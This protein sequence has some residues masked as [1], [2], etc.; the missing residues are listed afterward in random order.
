MRAVVL[1]LFVIASVEMC[2]QV[3]NRLAARHERIDQVYEAEKYGETIKLIDAQLDEAMG[4]PWADSLHLYLYK[5]GRAHRKMKD[6]AAGIAAA[7]RIYTLVKERGNAEHELEALFDLSWTYYDVG[8]MRQCARVDSTAIAVADRDPEMPLSQRGRASQYLAFD[9]SVL[10]DHR[11]SA[12]YALAALEVYAKADSIPPAQW[13]ESYTAVGVAYWHLGRIREAEVYYT[14]ALEALGDGTS[15][16]ILS[17]KVS[18]YG[19]LGVMWQNAGDFTRSKTYY[20]A[21]LRNSDRV[22][23]AATDPFVRD[24]AIVNRSRTYLN[25]ATVHFQLGDDGRARELLDIAWKDRSAVLEADDPQLLVVRDRMADLELSAGALDKAEELVSAYLGS[26]ERKFGKRSEEYIRACSKLGDIALRKGDLSRADSLFNVSIAAGKLN[27]DEG[28]DAVLVLTLQSRARMALEAGRG[29]DAIEDLLHARRILMTI[30]DSVHYKVAHADVLLAEAAFKMDDP[31]AALE[32]SRAAIELLDDR[33]R[34]LRASRTPRTFPDPHVLPDAIYWNVRAQRA[35]NGSGAVNK[36]WND[37]LDLAITSLARNRAAVK[38]EASK[39]LLIGAQKQ[40]FDLALDVAYDGYAKSGSEDDLER[41]LSLSE[42]DR[43]ILLNSR[44]NAFAGLRFVGVPDSITTKEQELLTAMDLDPEDREATADMDRRERAYADFIARIEKEY[45]A[46]FSL[47]YGASTIRLAD[48]R[49]RLLTEGRTLLDYAM[50]DEYLYGLVITKEKAALTRVSNKGIAEA[51]ELVNSSIALRTNDAYFGAAHE[52]YTLVVAP[53]AAQLIGEELLIIPDD[54]L[55]KVNFE[56]L[57][58]SPSTAKD[59]RSHLLVKNYAI[60]YLLSAT[61][62]LQ[63][64]ELARE[65]AQGTLAIAPGFTDQLKKDYLAS[66]MDTALVDQGY[67]RY[68]RQPFAVNTAKGLG[69]T[70]S[71]K[72]MVGGDAT[73]NGFRE[74]ASNYGILHLG[75]HAEM[76]ASSP[77]YSRLVLGKDGSGVDPDADGY[78]HAY[79]IYE[80]DLR[81]QLAV[82]TACETGTGKQDAGE[83]VRSLGY[84]FAY[85]GCPSLVMSLWSIDEK[86]TSEIIGRFYANLADG[87]PKHQALRQAKLDHLE[88]AQDELTLPYYWAGLVLVGD[89]SPVQLENGWKRYAWWVGVALFLILSVLIWRSRRR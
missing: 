65:R 57:L 31:K 66:V 69:R 26:C 33:V 14:K 10:G 58:S 82:L 28:M 85:A 34:A 9:Y 27:M 49:E 17:R 11:N 22:I 25:L 7:E 36:E 41:F 30:Y 60:A 20:H 68:I 53:I 15:G 48:V 77:L 1:C 63:F 71:A 59:F 19:N 47:R 87:M 55:H 42:A 37:F 84:S 39:L 50:T 16:S 62:A 81:A 56:V 44:L 79:E 74:L 89:V 13:G 52:L 73:E 75:T 12:K 64:A 67:L 78:L 21:S 8:E 46:Y 4:S 24:E 80:L 18:A 70:L 3:G 76:N 40:L 54:A 51:V 88:H 6:P 5:Y 23:A 83:G 43:S 86:T 2:A 38:D 72:V 32:Y 61:T 29:A 35:L 45:P